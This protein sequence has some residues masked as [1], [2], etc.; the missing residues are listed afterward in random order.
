MLDYF[1][2][3]G[4]E[5]GTATPTTNMN[6]LKVRRILQMVRDLTG[7][8]L[9]QLS[10]LDLACGEGVYAIECALRG[11]K[12]VAIDA[13]TERMDVGREF[14]RRLTL[15]NLRFEQGDVRNVSVES[16]GRFDVILFMGIL[17][18]LDVPD[19]FN[20]LKRLVA[21]CRHALI[22]DSH[23][24]ILPFDSIEYEGHTYYGRRG[25]E[26]ADGDSADVRRKHILMSTDNTFSFHFGRVSLVNL[27]ADIGFTSVF[28]CQVPLDPSKPEHRITLAAVRTQP[29]AVS[30]Y[31]WVNGKTREELTA[32]FPAGQPL[33]AKSFLWVRQ[34]LRKLGLDIRRV[35]RDTKAEHP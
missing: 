23:V 34:L 13:R 18:H 1:A 29:T 32:L 6:G 5:D 35:P 14:A 15:D 12:V 10:I 27:L 9:D 30:S 19:S 17:Y 8:P 21:M 24:A 28:E 31:P 20:V 4:C 11:A 25:R 22:I 7:R 3:K 33:R 26:H 2:R 16:H